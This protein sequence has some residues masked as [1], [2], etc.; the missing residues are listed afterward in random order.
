MLFYLWNCIL[1]D[2]R[3]SQHFYSLF[4]FYGPWRT[5]TL[6]YILFYV[7]QHSDPDCTAQI[8]MQFQTN[9][10]EIMYKT[11]LSRINTISLGSI[12]ADHLNLCRILFIDIKIELV[13][14]WTSIQQLNG[15]TVW[16]DQMWVLEQIS[17]LQSCLIFQIQVVM[18]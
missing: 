13:F 5:S 14:S 18:I 4:L 11:V 1:E 12:K 6:N 7:C 15:I 9:L 3:E 17:N 10:L 8:Q 16:L 2:L